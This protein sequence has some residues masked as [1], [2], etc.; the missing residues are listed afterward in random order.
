MIQLRIIDREKDLPTL[1][2]RFLYWWKGHGWEG[3]PA[4]VLPRLGILAEDHHEEPGKE[5]T[6]LAAGWIY[7][8]NS[9]GVSMLEWLVTDPDAKPLQTAKAIKALIPFARQ[10]AKALGYGVMLAAVRQP[11]LIRLLESLEFET[12]DSG[13]THLISTL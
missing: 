8:D 2:P 3:I 11:A 1:H 10:E 4:S 13:V 6:P 5:P 9:I 7:M 12:T